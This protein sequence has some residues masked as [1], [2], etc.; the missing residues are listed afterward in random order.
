MQRRARGSP[1][2]VREPRPAAVDG[3]WSTPRDVVADTVRVA[4]LHATDAPRW[5]RKR[6][7]VRREGKVLA[8]GEN[9]CEGAG[10][11][12]KVRSTGSAARRIPIAAGVRGLVQ[13]ESILSA[14]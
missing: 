11:V 5:P 2:T 6:G 7:C 10:R 14:P 13:P 9:A 12:S 4:V 8:W 1:P 3:D